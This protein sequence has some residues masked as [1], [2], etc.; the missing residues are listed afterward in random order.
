M[1]A[2]GTGG[3]K[4]CVSAFGGDQFRLPHQGAEL[5]RFFSLFYFAI[6][7]GSMISTAVTPFLRAD[8]QCFG[9][10]DCYSLAF[11]VPAVLM[12][13]SMGIFMAGRSRY[14]VQPPSGNV[15]FGVSNCI[16]NAYKG[17]KT[18]RN[19]KPL[20]QFLDYAE[21]FVGEQMVHETKSLFKVLLLYVPFPLFWALSDQ[22]GSR[23]TFQAMHMDGEV[24]GHEIKPD[25]MQVINPLLILAFI[26]LFDCTVYPLLARFGIKRPLQK[27]G[28]GMLCASISFFLSAHVELRLERLEPK[29]VP[30]FHNMVHLRLYNGMPCRYEFISE[31]E[32]VAG[33]IDSLAMWSNLELRVPRAMVVGLRA[34]SSNE[35][36]P[37]IEGRLHLRP[38]QSVSYF[39]TKA[40]L[41]EF[42]DGLRT[43]RRLN[44]PLLLRTLIN[45][46]PEEGPIWLRAPASSLA[47]VQLD[48][49]NLSALHEVALGYGEL[50]INGKR[51]ASFD[52]RKGGLYS[53]LVQGNERDGYVSERA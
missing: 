6:N 29:A 46:P 11:G 21:P 17:W 44:R 26:P 50:D 12:L 9:D 34:K 8:V 43:V 52:A 1:I 15:I 4:P 23:W 47:G 36:C 53:L 38:G 41:R 24:F 10:E 27:L 45:A 18:N 2:V 42:S 48:I 13:V 25:Q 19:R 51:V 16:S 14:R 7:A 49:G 31:H 39:L 35:R 32:A 5:A 40:G 20:P 28:L 37:N 33:S 22:Q 30:K 3:I